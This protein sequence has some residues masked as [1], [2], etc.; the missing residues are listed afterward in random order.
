MIGQDTPRGLGGNTYQRELAS[1]GPYQFFA[2]FRN[3][4]LDYTQFYKSLP[5]EKVAGEIRAEL[6]ES[7]ARF[8]GQEAIQMQTIVGLVSAGMGVALV[9]QSVS[10]LMR[11]GTGGFRARNR[12]PAELRE[13]IFEPFYRLPGASEREGGVGL[14]LVFLHGAGKCATWQ[15]DQAMQLWPVLPA[16]AVTDRGQGV[17]WQAQLTGALKYLARRAT[18]K[19]QALGQGSKA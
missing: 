6:S 19:A 4:E 17:E 16:D 8:I 5:A 18:Y 9:P 3:N 13:R 2:A 12:W 11:P 14:G 15:I 7:N 10:N 1:N